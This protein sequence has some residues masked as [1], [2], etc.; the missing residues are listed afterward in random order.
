M[1]RICVRCDKTCVQ[2]SGVGARMYTHD[3]DLENTFVP[4]VR[5]IQ[6]RCSKI[7]YHTW[8]C[9]SADTFTAFISSWLTYTIT[10]SPSWT[11][12]PR[13]LSIWPPLG[14]LRHY[15]VLYLQY[16][17]TKQGRESC[18][19]CILLSNASP[20]RNIGVHCTNRGCTLNPTSKYQDIPSLN[21]YAGRSNGYTELSCLQQHLQA[22][23]Q[24][25][26]IA[27]IRFPV[28]AC[29]TALRKMTSAACSRS[30]RSIAG[31]DGLRRAQTSCQ[32]LPSFLFAVL[33]RRSIV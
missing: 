12:A 30:Q 14:R 33:G 3:P 22:L 24:A 31:C 21:Q 4:Y 16:E 17:A 9:P 18:M 1:Y 10:K 29:R 7:P 27:R 6:S 5:P 2:S 11:T 23:D 19:H 15:E 25:W 28:N 13:A 26:N 20:S 32:L 8:V